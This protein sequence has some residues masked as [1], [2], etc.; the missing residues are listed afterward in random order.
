MR[1]LPQN[2]TSKAVV[3][4]DHMLSD[5]GKQPLI[6][7]VHAFLLRPVPSSGAAADRCGFEPN[8]VVDAFCCAA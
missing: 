8:D 6:E 4:Y 5:D 2:D 7:Q 3:V 1:K